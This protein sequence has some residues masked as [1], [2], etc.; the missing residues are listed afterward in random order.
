[1]AGLHHIENDTVAGTIGGTLLAILPNL[2]T[3]DITRTIVLGAVGAIASFVIT[4]LCKWALKKLKNK[5][6]NRSKGPKK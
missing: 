5:F 3:T 2:E 1:M 6:F 4:Q